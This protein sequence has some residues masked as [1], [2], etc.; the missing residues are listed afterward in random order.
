MPRPVLVTPVDPSGEQKDPAVTAPPAPPELGTVVVTA[1]IV[2]AVGF[3]VV[4]TARVVA[5]AWVAD[6]A[7]VVGAVVAGAW[8]VV[9]A[10]SCSA[11]AATYTSFTRAG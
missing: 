11:A 7:M 2:V 8:V 5:G 10:A 6:G 1:L 4:A 3:V 9:V